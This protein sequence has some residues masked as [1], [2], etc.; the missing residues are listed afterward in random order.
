MPFLYE[1]TIDNEKVEG[2]IGFS[3][4]RKWEEALDEATLVIPFTYEN[5]TPYKMFSMLNIEIIEIDN[6]IDRHTIDTRTYEFI[7]YSDNVKSLGSYG[8]YRHQVNAIE[9]TAKLD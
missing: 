7:I 2:Q 3:T 8:Y 5:D 1:F 6:Y 9:Y 4:S